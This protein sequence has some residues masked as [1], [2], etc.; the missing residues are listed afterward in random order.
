MDKLIPGP[1]SAETF[2]SIILLLLISWILGAILSL[3]TKG[4]NPLN[5]NR[6]KKDE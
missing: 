5:L 6:N 3:I 2:G 4:N 1:T